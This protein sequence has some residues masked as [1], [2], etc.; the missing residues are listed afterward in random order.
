MSTNQPIIDTHCHYNLEPLFSGEKSET[1]GGWQDH[2]QKARSHGVIASLVAGTTLEDSSKAIEIA[3]Q[4]KGLLAGVG[5][6]PHAAASSLSDYQPEVWHQVEKQVEK[7][8]QAEEIKETKRVIEMVKAID[9]TALPKMLEADLTKLITT[10]KTDVA[11]MG[12]IG[13]DYYRRP[14]VLEQ[15]AQQVVF[16]LQLDLAVEH[17]LP[18]IIHARDRDD[19]D[20][21][22]TNAYWLI[23]E[24]IKQRV[25]ANYPF[26]LHCVSGPWDYIKQ[27]LAHGAWLGIAGNITYPNAKELRKLVSKVAPEKLVTETDAPYLAPQAYRGQ[28]CQP[29]MIKETARHLVEQKI[30]SYQQLIENAARFCPKLYE[31]Y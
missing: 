28:V 12:E 22:N 29:F 30:I 1:Q 10:S 13:L 18:I 7:I 31:V 11:V 5:I 19:H 16:G 14:P 2:W 26:V 20:D 15:A 21:K 3:Y 27:A 23:L 4:T 8:A 24:N 6:H 17:Q 9:E 25:P